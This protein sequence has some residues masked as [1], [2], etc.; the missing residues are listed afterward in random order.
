[1][2]TEFQSG[3][4]RKFW[5]QAVGR[6]TQQRELCL[7]SLNCILKNIKIANVM[8]CVFYHNKNKTLKICRWQLPLPVIR[9]E[10]EPSSHRPA[11]PPRG[12]CPP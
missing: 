2:G 9:T 6:V 4:R 3:E 10:G 1:M 8:F 11:A 7:M 12:L 5:R